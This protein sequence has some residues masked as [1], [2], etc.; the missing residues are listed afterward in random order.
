[1]LLTVLNLFHYKTSPLRTLRIPGAM[2]I[3]TP[4]ESE[5]SSPGLARFFLFFSFFFFFLNLNSSSKNMLDMFRVNV[6]VRTFD[7][8][9]KSITMSKCRGVT[10]K[11]NKKLTKPEKNKNESEETRS[12]SFN[13]EQCRN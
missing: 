7:D 13:N 1:M 9:V 12:D 4:L 10:L 3:S 11:K 8:T 2:D 6:H 5:G